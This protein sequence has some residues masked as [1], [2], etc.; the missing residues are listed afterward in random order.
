MSDADTANG[1]G[2]VAFETALGFDRR[3]RTVPRRQP[4]VEAEPQQIDEA[5]QTTNVEIEPWEVHSELVLVC[6]EVWK[7][8]L[9]LLPER[10]PDAFLTRPPAP[11]SLAAGPAAQAEVAASLA[12]AVLAYALLR[13]AETARCALVAVAALVTLALLAEALH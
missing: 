11:R 6:P 7:R 3:L 4:A 8:A 2:A 13:L 5:L 1:L 12:T 9:E 10:D